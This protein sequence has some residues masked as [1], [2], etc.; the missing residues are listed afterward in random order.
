MTI[1]I[2]AR[3][4]RAKG[5]TLM[6]LEVLKN[7]N[8]HYYFVFHDSLFHI[9][10]WK[11]SLKRKKWNNHWKVW[12]NFFS[13]KSILEILVKN[14]RMFIFPFHPCRFLE[15]VRSIFRKFPL[16]AECF[17]NLFSRSRTTLSSY[18]SL[19]LVRPK[20]SQWDFKSRD[21]AGHFVIFSDLLLRIWFE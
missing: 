19:S 8:N 16:V 10:R 20:V 7:W 21:W 5:S 13:F 12:T 17:I 3:F 14:K 11:K 4:L 1:I 15:F 18:L 2:T 9:S 6:T